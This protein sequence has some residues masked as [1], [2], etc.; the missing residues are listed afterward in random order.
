MGM[1]FTAECPFC[2]V[3]LPGVPDDRS[4]ASAEC[5]RCKNLFTVAAVIRPQKRQ[6]IVN[7]FSPATGTTVVPASGTESRS[8][9]ASELH[10]ALV[11]TPPAENDLRSAA[12]VNGFGL[13]AFFLSTMA[14]LC[15]SISGLNSIV[16]PMAGAALLLGGL[17]LLLGSARKRG[18][19]LP[20]AGLAVSIPVVTIGYWWPEKLGLPAPA[21]ANDASET[22]TVYHLADPAGV[23]RVGPRLADWVDASK[24]AIQQEGIRVRI[25]SVEVKP[26][27]LKDA[28]GRRR[29]ADRSLVIQLRVSNASADRLVEYKSWGEAED[30]DNELSARLTDNSDKPYRL[31]RF[32]AGWNIPGHVPRASLPTAKW[33][34]DVLVFEAPPASITSLRLELPRAA[35]GAKG[36]LQLEIPRHMITFP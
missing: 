27:N 23:Q 16:L 19:T 25:A 20:L 33:V 7:R 17:G 1:S 12:G 36:K 15:A 2:H 22:Q 30:T 10:R 11:C 34:D 6:N 35:F 21:A 24:E 5:P 18:L 31:K 32:A 4:G 14:L 13:A 9:P 3:M 28:H 8:S 29:L 26:V